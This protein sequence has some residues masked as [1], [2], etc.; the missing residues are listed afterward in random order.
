M[1]KLII[2]ITMVFMSIIVTFFMLELGVRLTYKFKFR[3]KGIAHMPAPKTYRMSQNKKLLFELVPRSKA[4]IKGITYKI[5]AFGFRDKQ[6]RERKAQKKRIIF[7]GDSLTYGWVIPLND[8]YHK[9]LEKLMTLKG[10]SIDVWGMGVIGY[11]TI[12]EYQ[13]IKENVVR[14]NPDMVIIQM[15]PNDF[16][17]RLGVRKKPDDKEFVLTLY[18]DFSIPYVFK[19]GGITK[20]LMQNS[21]LFRFMNLKIFWLKKK[22]NEDYTPEE[23]YLLGE[24]KSFQYLERIKNYL[25]N[26]EIPLSI[27]IFA[28][29]KIEDDY[30]YASLH[31]RIHEKLD[32]MKVP[33]LDLYEEFNLNNKGKNI[34]L[35]RL[36]PNANGYQIAAQKLSEFLIPL[37]YDSPN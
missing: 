17:R 34:W 15:C 20:F 25:D 13:V 33:Y 27:V 19:K 7:V 3:S 9:Q 10:H 23:V 36:H 8:T 18:H 31:K 2:R 22:R 1:K 14:F 11:N 24:E 37:L 5:N 21:H 30:I 12:Q 35:D 6:Y 16:E 26:K 4:H 32:E 29:R 28:F